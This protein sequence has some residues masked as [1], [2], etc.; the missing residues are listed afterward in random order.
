MSKLGKE[1]GIQWP[2]ALPMVLHVIR[3]TP[4]GPLNLSPYEMLF[5]KLPN[6]TL[7]INTSPSQ[8]NDVTV[9]TFYCYYTS[10]TD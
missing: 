10:K 1:T 6:I 8:V 5:G 3:R 4:P 9:T 2:E 7:D